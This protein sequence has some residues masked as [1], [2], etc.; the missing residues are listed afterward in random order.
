MIPH[1]ERRKAICFLFG[2]R[3]GRRELLFRPRLE[4]K[5]FKILPFGNQRIETKK[6][7]N[8]ISE[9]RTLISPKFIKDA[10]DAD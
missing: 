2:T 5:V 8:F 4:N 3:R 6:G 1:G 10:Q 7:L 9:H